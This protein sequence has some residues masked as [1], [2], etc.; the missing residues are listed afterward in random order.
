MP[1]RRARRVQESESNLRGAIEQSHEQ[2]RLS[3]AVERAIFGTQQ[4][5]GEELA[6]PLTAT[7]VA[8]Q[9]REGVRLSIP[10]ISHR[11]FD[12]E[13]QTINMA[14]A[15]NDERITD[16]AVRRRYGNVVGG[17][18]FIGIEN[19]GGNTVMRFESNRHS[20]ATE[21]NNLQSYVRRIIGQILSNHAP[22]TVDD[23]RVAFNPLPW[24]RE[25]VRQREDSLDAFRYWATPLERAN[26]LANGPR[27]ARESSLP[28]LAETIASRAYFAEFCDSRVGAL[29]QY[30]RS[31]KAMDL[32]I[33]LREVL[34][35]SLTNYHFCETV[36]GL[37]S[38]ITLSDNKMRTIQESMIK[39]GFALL[40]RKVLNNDW[41]TRDFNMPKPNRLDK[42]HWTRFDIDAMIQ[43]TLNDGQV[44]YS[45]RGENKFIWRVDLATGAVVLND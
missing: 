14:V 35:T 1:R 44:M 17:W 2:S 37:T 31:T 42:T 38:L 30:F 34:P 9:G 21:V 8:M 22:V 11:T 13:R 12:S 19:Q 7:E 40:L 4:R 20:S 32:Y 39:A 10:D 29:V 16:E 43:F 5:I 24:S 28:T 36:D 15:P 18:R 6:R 23:G 45:Q 3:P 25:A 27:P 26:E 33:S 41:R